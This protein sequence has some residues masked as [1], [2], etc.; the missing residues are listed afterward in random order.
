MKRAL[1]CCIVLVGCATGTDAS[2]EDA[3]AGEAGDRFEISAAD[4]TLDW[5]LGDAVVHEDG[6]WTAT[7]SEG[8]VVTVDAGWIVD[9]SVTLSP[10][11]D[12]VVAALSDPSSD[13]D[14]L[15]AASEHRAACLGLAHRSTTALLAAVGGGGMDL[16][17]P[18]QRLAREAMFYVIQAQTTDG[19]D[20]VLRAAM[21]A[22]R[23][24]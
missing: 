11:D 4:W 14:V 10:C 19:R 22:D 20:A 17:H 15:A 2:T 18:A 6:G 16:S 7:T 13:H 23:G 12:E 5:D 24:T 8:Y 1:L 21:H 3:A 9:Y